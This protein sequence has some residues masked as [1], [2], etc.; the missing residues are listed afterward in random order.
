MKFATQQDIIDLGFSGFVPTKRLQTSAERSVIPETTG[1]YMILHIAE[2][3]PVFKPV[4]GA[5]GKTVKKSAYAVEDLQKKWLFVKGTPVIYIG[6]AGGFPVTE[7][8]LRKRLGQYLRLSEGHS[9]G[10][11][12][13]Q[14]ADCED[15]LV[16]WKPVLGSDPAIYESQ[17][18]AAFFSRYS[19]LPLANWIT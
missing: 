4:G 8:H 6:K 2:T 1:V 14:L 11:A 3:E 7:T 17:L 10:R 15:L 18:R 9:G 12:I 19:S 16:C 13:W 5:F